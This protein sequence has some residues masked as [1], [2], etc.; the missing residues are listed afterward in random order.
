MVLPRALSRGQRR[1]IMKRSSLQAKK[2]FVELALGKKQKVDNLT[3]FGSL[4][5]FDEMLDA[6][7]KS[8]TTES[9]DDSHIARR[10]IAKAKRRTGTLS[11]KKKQK[12]DDVDIRRYQTLL[13][14]PEFS[15]DPLAAM[16]KHLQQL[17][18]VRET[19]SKA[20]NRSVSVSNMDTS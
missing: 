16:E 6:V 7:V 5:D 17:K 19:K 13:K 12:S 1:R 15:K 4:G 3:N 2:Q 8:N 11:R 10:S 14:V 20:T 18:A 9:V